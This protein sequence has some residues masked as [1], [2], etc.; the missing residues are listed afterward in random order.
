MLDWENLPCRE[1]SPWDC[2]DTAWEYSIGGDSL[3]RKLSQGGLPAKNVSDYHA[4]GDPCNS[5]LDWGILPFRELSYGKTDY[6]KTN[7]Q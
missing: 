2:E 3:S 4:C 6:L 1:L 5:M 7:L